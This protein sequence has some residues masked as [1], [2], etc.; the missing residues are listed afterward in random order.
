MAPAICLIAGAGLVAMLYHVFKGRG[1]VKVRVVDGADEPVNVASVP[2]GPSRKARILCR[3]VSDLS[4]GAAGGR[5][6]GAQDA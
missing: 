2:G 3:T 1:T 6:R 4:P 5:R